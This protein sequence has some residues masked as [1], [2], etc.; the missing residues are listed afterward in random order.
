MKS[1]YYDQND[2]IISF[3]PQSQIYPYVRIECYS[4]IE[5]ESLE[6]I[7]LFIEALQKARDDFK[8]HLK[9]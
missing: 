9:K 4:E 1:V 6:D 7:D 8:A 2:V 3:R 5:F